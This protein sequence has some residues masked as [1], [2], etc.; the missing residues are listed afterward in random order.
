[1]EH[2]SQATSSLFLQPARGT[3]GAVRL[4]HHMPAPGCKGEILTIV[5]RLLCCFSNNSPLNAG[6][7]I[8]VLREGSTLRAQIDRR[9]Y[10]FVNNSS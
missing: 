6:A 2:R 1:M 7:D 10:N 8:E 5:R 4:E 3:S 9:F